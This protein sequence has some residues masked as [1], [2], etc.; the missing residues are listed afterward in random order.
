[1]TSIVMNTYILLSFQ[2]FI[3]YY[4]QIFR[5]ERIEKIYKESCQGEL[6]P[7]QKDVVY[8][9]QPPIYTVFGYTIL[10][11]DYTLF[12][13]LR[14]EQVLAINPTTGKRIHIDTAGISNSYIESYMGVYHT[15]K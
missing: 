3:D 1:M 9:L 7:T 12:G 6:D 15:A 4:K 14:V 10:S 8:C 13:A 5:Q 11:R 2:N